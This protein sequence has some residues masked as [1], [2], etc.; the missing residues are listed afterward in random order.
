M[1]LISYE[2]ISKPKCLKVKL[3]NINYFESFS[4]DTEIDDFEN[5]DCCL[6]CPYFNRNYLNRFM[7]NDKRIYSKSL[8]EDLSLLPCTFSDDSAMK[9]EGNKIIHNGKDGWETCLIGEPMSKDVYI[10]R[11]GKKNCRCSFG[12]V[13]GSFTDIRSGKSI[14]ELHA[15]VEMKFEITDRL[16]SVDDSG[17]SV[18]E[19]LL[20]TSDDLSAVVKIQGDD[21]VFLLNKSNKKVGFGYSLKCQPVSIEID[22]RSKE[23]DKR[24]AFFYI[25]SNHVYTYFFG[26]P[27]TVRFAVCNL[28]IYYIYVYFVNVLIFYIIF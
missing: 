12:I 10:I 2:K 25:G 16:K 26:L 19:K 1:S 20:T 21:S 28:I 13:D 7:I 8:V 17:R 15:G 6:L 27:S 3:E 5:D 22:L 11:I 24:C 14:S 18:K 23:S 9:I 4:A